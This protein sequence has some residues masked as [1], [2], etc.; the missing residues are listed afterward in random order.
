MDYRPSPHFQPH[1][2]GFYCG[3]SQSGSLGGI[4]G[5]TPQDLE[6][7]P[8][9][10][11]HPVAVCQQESLSF[12]EL[13]GRFELGHWPL[14]VPPASHGL[15]WPLP[16]A[17]QDTRGPAF[18]DDGLSE[19]LGGPRSPQHPEPQRRTSHSS[20][21][22]SAWRK[23]RVYESQEVTGSPRAE[24]DAVFPEVGVEV[25]EPHPALEVPRTL[26]TA[27]TP[28]VGPK[29]PERRRFS[30]SELMSRLQ[31]AQRKA[32]LSL[33]L[34]KG[35]TKDRGLWAAR[36]GRA[37]EKEPSCSE[38]RVDGL[39]P[40]AISG[41]SERD[42]SWPDTRPDPLEE[43]APKA[44]APHE[45]RQSRFLL[46]SVLYQEYSDVASDRELQRQK[47]EED[48]LGEEAEEEEEGPGPPRANLSPSSSFRA[49][50]S[51][52]GST[53]SLWQDIPDVR[54]SGFLAIIGL[55][56]RKLQEA[57]FELITSEA[58]YIHSLSVAVGHFMGSSELAECLGAQEKQ[59]LFSKLSE[60]K[61]TSERFLQ[62]LEQRLEE[63]ILRFCVCD[64]VLRHCPAFRRVYLPYV[65]NQAYQE[66]TYQRLLLE[67]PKFS[68]VLA[69]LEEAPICQRLPLT[70]FLILPF[71]RITRLK[72]LVE[73]ILKR[74]GQGS[75]GEDMATRAFNELKKLVQECN[76]SV[77]SMKRTEELIHLNKKI[78]FESKIF[79]LISQS[80]W[81]VRHGELVELAPPTMPAVSAAKPKLST[82]AIYLHVFNDCLLLSRRK[83]MEK[84]AVFL[85][86]RMP[87]IRVK[88][89]SSKLQGI[90]GQVFLL[91]FLHSH[92]PKSQ[93]LLRAQTESEK[94]RWISAMCPSSTQEDKEAISENEDLPQVQCIRA[95][96]ALEPD[97][98]T[99]EKAD[100]LAVRTRTSDGWLEGIR[101]ADGERGWVPQAYVDEITSRS[102]RLRNI[103][104]TRMIESATNKL[105][106]AAA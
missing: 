83:E 85:Y 81:L 49:Q 23:M 45:R 63:D 62:E 57:K 6:E 7:L 30:A 97:E 99:L 102:A 59:W 21:E 5:K 12:A 4:P 53:F 104:E 79:P 100:I 52:R 27:V 8:P 13:P 76:A 68:S 82:K 48:T 41:P 103:R 38:M 98:L 92:Q 71:Q 42:D 75:R 14:K 39:V 80:R 2:A 95:Y 91:Q 43:A 26:V 70:S 25:P 19:F 50:R 54:S 58:S 46:N 77:Q 20:E 40:P 106:E 11:R 60:V 17:T 44:W 51:G 22:K 10:A 28:R 29:E 101:L 9:P 56:E 73:N 16:V 15:L 88:D 35:L 67:N 32:T 90:P 78:H 18:G 65:T 84:F 24:D 105:Q 61:A 31:S 66:S 1:L 36:E 37:P 69:R 47:H 96:K 89:L 34:G 3:G 87:E 86:A 74:T 93:L 33:C 55:Q 72:M 94:Q 64:I